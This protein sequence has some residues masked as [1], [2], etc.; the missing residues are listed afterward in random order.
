MSYEALITFRLCQELMRH[1]DIL[2]CSSALTE[3]DHL[4]IEGMYLLGDELQDFSVVLT[5]D[6]LHFYGETPA[7]SEELPYHLVSTLAE[8]AGIQNTFYCEGM[9][10]PLLHGADLSTVTIH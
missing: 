5:E 8:E 4:A 1:E 2:L 6:C 7:A 3:N 10:A 9:K